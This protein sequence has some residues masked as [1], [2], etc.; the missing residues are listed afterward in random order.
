MDSP[1]PSP[2]AFRPLVAGHRLAITLL[3]NALACKQ[4]HAF[5]T[6]EHRRGLLLPLCDGTGAEWLRQDVRDCR[7]MRRA[8]GLHHASVLGEAARWTTLGLVRDCLILIG[9]ST[10]RSDRQNKFKDVFVELDRPGQAGTQQCCAPTGRLRGV[11][12]LARRAADEDGSPRS[13]ARISGI[14][15]MARLFWCG[16]IIAELGETWW[17]PAFGLRRRL[18]L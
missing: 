14:S 15:K 13:F 8:G 6:D 7:S 12:V 1:L 18:P 16:Y 17:A 2:Q 10:L 5:P 9:R 11:G 3:A 4:I